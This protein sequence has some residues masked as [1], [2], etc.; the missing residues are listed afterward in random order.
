MKLKIEVKSWNNY[1]PPPHTHTPRERWGL[2]RLTLHPKTITNG[3]KI[4]QWDDKMQNK[5][6]LAYIK[7]HGVHGS[8]SGTIS[9]SEA[10]PLHLQADPKLTFFRGFFSLFH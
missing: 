7:L 6:C 2:I 3:C 5:S 8:P 9:G 1:P 10:Y 4:V